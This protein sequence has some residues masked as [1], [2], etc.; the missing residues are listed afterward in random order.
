MAPG[1][2]ADYQRLRCSNLSG[3]AN[4]PG[5]VQIGVRRPLV[6]Q[7]QETTTL[8]VDTYEMAHTGHIVSCATVSP[9]VTHD[10]QKGTEAVLHPGSTDTAG[11]VVIAST[12]E[13]RFTLRVL[14]GHPMRHSANTKRTLFIQLTPANEEASKLKGAYFASECSK[15][16]W[17][18]GFE[19][20]F[21]E[22]CEVGQE[23]YYA[24]TGGQTISC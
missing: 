18:E 15:D 2:V 14:F 6:S 7:S 22:G 20:T 21:P 13:S 17:I 3:S 24:V 19:I 10:I 9:E 5:Q 8:L 11:K 12:Q 23:F 16:A 4:T 1:K